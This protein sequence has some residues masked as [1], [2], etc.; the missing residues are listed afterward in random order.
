LGN[1]SWCHFRYPCSDSIRST[2]AAYLPIEACRRAQHTDDDDPDSRR[3]PHGDQHSSETRNKLDEY[4][5]FFSKLFHFI[6]CF[7]LGWITFLV[8][9]LL[10]GCLLII[11]IS[12]KVRQHK[13][14]IDDFGNPIRP[15]FPSSSWSESYLAESEGAPRVVA[16]LAE[17]PGAVRVVLVGAE[18]DLRTPC[19]TASVNDQTPLLDQIPGDQSKKQR[20]WSKWFGRR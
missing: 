10:Q 5:N 3:L 17:T 7:W 13:L 6:D 12:W 4:E 16:D 19:T 9:A 2:A 1:F 11:C 14:G 15:E 18:R 8:A 20:L